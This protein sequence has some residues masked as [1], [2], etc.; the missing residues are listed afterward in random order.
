MGVKRVKCEITPIQGGSPYLAFLVLGFCHKRVS[1]LDGVVV[2][3]DLRL[4]TAGGSL[5][6]L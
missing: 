2:W 6:I 4:K 5:E 1:G 3:S